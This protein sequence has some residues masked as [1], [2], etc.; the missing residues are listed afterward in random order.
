[1]TPRARIAR[2]LAPAIA[3]A[4]LLEEQVRTSGSVRRSVRSALYVLARRS[5]EA[6]ELVRIRVRRI[7]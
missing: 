5:R 6:R 4:R 3:V 1:M 7:G 2:A